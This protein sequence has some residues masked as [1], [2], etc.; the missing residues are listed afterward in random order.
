L[1][2]QNI[3][4]LSNFLLKKINYLYK[5]NKKIF[6]LEKKFLILLKKYLS[7]FS[8]WSFTETSIFTWQIE[9]SVIN[10]L[11]L[12]RNFLLNKKV[13]FLKKVKSK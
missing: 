9:F 12:S 11:C 5:E 2:S 13:F 8:L 10:F 6:F 1:I 7:R 3:L 4:F